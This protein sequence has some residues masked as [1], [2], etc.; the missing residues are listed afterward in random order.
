MTS[1]HPRK[2][3]V[4][5]EAMAVESGIINQS[6]E[7]FQENAISSHSKCIW[8][9]PNTRLSIQNALECTQY[10]TFHSKCIGMHPIQDFPFKMHWNP[11]NT[12]LSHSHVKHLHRAWQE[13]AAYLCN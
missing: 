13:A 10:K 1:I 5:Y 2:G 4:V 7:A 3:I 11:P 6:L 12:R 8:N 9:P